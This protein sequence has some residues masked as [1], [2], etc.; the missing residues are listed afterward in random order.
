MRA[1]IG[2][3]W[4]R[5]A[6]ALLA[7]GAFLV[8]FGDLAN[9]PSVPSAQAQYGTS[10]RVARRT[11]RRTSNR[12]MAYADAAAPQTVV[13]VPAGCTSNGSTYTCPNNAQY[14]QVMQGDQVVYE[15]TQ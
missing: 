14:Q 4:S 9:L 10:R 6:A 7:I 12:Q 1:R 8:D 2:S 3:R 15:Q 13:A 11:A 5:G